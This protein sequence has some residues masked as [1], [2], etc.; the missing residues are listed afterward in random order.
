MAVTLAQ[1]P[2]WSPVVTTGTTGTPLADASAVRVAAMEPRRD[3]GDDS[4][5]G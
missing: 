2:Q 1:A 3:D 4:T 5:R